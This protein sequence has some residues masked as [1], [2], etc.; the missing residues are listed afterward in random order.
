MSG[1]SRARRVAAGVLVLM[2]SA[3]GVASAQQELFEQGNQRYQEGDWAGA[4]ASYQAVLD[5]GF[6]SADLHYNLGNAYFKSGRLGPAILEW[7]RARRLAPS[8]QDI[9]ANLELARSLTADVVEPLPTFWVIS[10][11]RWWVRA[12]PRG[13]LVLT[14]ALGWL[15]LTGG[16]IARI[17]G[18]SDDLR[19]WGRRIEL[20]GVAVVVVL[21]ANLAAREL[22]I[23]EAER[24]VILAEV[25]PVRSAPAEDDN[26]TL[27]EVHEGTRVRIDQRA[28]T[29]AEVVLDDGKVGWIPI[30]AM[31]VI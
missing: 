21:G 19:R 23:G 3:S 11:V 2:A 13:L 29:W 12:L 25:V 14:V 15:G 28:G 17:L 24:A 9:A 18:R 1:R 6:E 10:V 5:A 4:L 16:A 26:L 31:G 30:D 27:F 8:D 20:G 7:E 22:G